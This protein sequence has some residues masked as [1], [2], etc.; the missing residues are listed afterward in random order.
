MKKAEREMTDYLWEV[1]RMIRAIRFVKACEWE[2][3]SGMEQIW[4]ET[5][6]ADLLD[7]CASGDLVCEDAVRMYEDAWRRKV[8]TMR[9]MEAERNE[10]R[11]KKTEK[12]IR[13]A[14]I[15]VGAN[16]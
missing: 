4:M 2:K 13:G 10:G 12:S 16:G 11:T 14:D 9:Q 15:N 7:M 5:T 1:T 3:A 6:A 8:A